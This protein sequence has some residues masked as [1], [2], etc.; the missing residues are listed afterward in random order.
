MEWKTSLDEAFLERLEEFPALR[1][2][3][4]V[5]HLKHLYRQGWLKAG[6]PKERCETV[7]DHI[8][9]VTMLCWLLI[10]AESAPQVNPERALRMAL[11]HELGEIY[12]GD[13]TPSDAIPAEEKHAR[14]RQSLERV[15]ENLPGAEDLRA[16]W[17]EFEAGATPEAR[18]VHQADRLEMALQAVTYV[19]EGVLKDP[20]SFFRSARQAVND[21]AL[22][23][24]LEIAKNF[25]KKEG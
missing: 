20:S 3:Y 7:S 6:V 15:L 1:A 23:E 17:E 5:Q 13:L 4:Q 11:I 22:Q 16:L 24:W 14:E 10:E 25:G 12:A 19:R 18:L 9:G 21:P 8:F 2:F